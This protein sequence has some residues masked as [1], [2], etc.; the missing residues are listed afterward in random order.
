MLTLTRRSRGER[1][2]KSQIVIRCACGETIV[3]TVVRSGTCEA[4]LSFE[5][6]KTVSIKRRELLMGEENSCN[7]PKTA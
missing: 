4:K 5:A 2:P 6:A 3:V 1:D 7:L